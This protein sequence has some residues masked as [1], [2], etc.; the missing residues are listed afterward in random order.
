MPPDPRVDGEVAVAEAFAVLV[1]QKKT[2]M[3][4]A[5]CVTTSSPTSPVSSLPSGSQEATAMPSARDWISPS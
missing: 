5:G 1:P 2:G 4:G 3:D